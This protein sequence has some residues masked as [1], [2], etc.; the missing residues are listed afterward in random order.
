MPVA[1]WV[2]VGDHQVLVA[3][4]VQVRH[5]DVHRPGAGRQV[6]RGLER[7]VPVVEQD[8]GRPAVADGRGHEVGVA[9]VVKVSGRHVGGRGPEGDGRRGQE[10]AVPVPLDDA[11]LPAQGVARHGHVEPAVGV[12]VG[13]GHAGRGGP[14][15]RGDR[16]LEG[17]VAVAEQH[18]HGTNA[19]RVDGH[20]VL[21]PVAVE[22]AGGDGHGR[23]ARRVSGGRQETLGRCGPQR[24]TNANRGPRAMRGRPWRRRASRRRKRS[25]DGTSRRM[26][27][28]GDLDRRPPRVSRAEVVVGRRASRPAVP[29]RVETARAAATNFFAAACNARAFFR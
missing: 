3:V 1:L 23:G 7:A 13:D 17:A 18:A 16:R 2:L 4:V 22:V 5:L 14:G 15:R 20:H 25:M 12:E 24:L 21:E 10:R 19:G 8:H 9:V 11:D 29:R 27:R 26:S 28:T 6:P